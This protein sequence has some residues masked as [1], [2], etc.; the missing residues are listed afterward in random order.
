MSAQGESRQVSISGDGIP[1]AQLLFALWLGCLLAV[2][3]TLLFYSAM[4]LIEQY[5]CKPDG[6][7]V[8]EEKSWKEEALTAYGL[9]FRVILAGAFGTAAA[10]GILVAFWT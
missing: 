4:R 6:D 7:V 5:W 8:E 2:E 9:A 3:M 1:F 10:S